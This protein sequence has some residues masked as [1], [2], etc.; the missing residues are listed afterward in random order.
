M[1]L[2]L[3]GL[4]LSLVLLAPSIAH[5]EN[6]SAPA[7]A[8]AV[9]EARRHFVRGVDLFKE[10]DHRGALIEFRRAQSLAPNFRV[11]FNIG[12]TLMMLQEY[13]GARDAFRG[14]LDKGSVSIPAPRRAAVEEE[15]KRLEAR[16][17]QVEI[18]VNV[19]GAEITIDDEVVG[20][21][22]LGGP[23]QVSA[24]RR[25]VTVSSAGTQSVT[26]YVDV[27]GADQ[28]VVEVTLIEAIHAPA[29]APAPIPLVIGDE[30]SVPSRARERN[31]GRPS[32]A[33]WIAAGATGILTAGAV[34]SGILALRAKSDLDKHV[35]S[36]GAEIADIDSA[37]NRAR[38]FSI[39]TDV[40]GACA[41]VA[42]GV[43]GYLFFTT[44]R[45]SGVAVA[46]SPGRVG[47]SGSF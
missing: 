28:T 44:R 34:V 4:V 36:P 29:V 15:V 21:A 47:L 9:D 16:I 19:P 13:A 27:V 33:P 20:V 8:A 43:T 38:T 42:A 5:A 2:Y 22:P 12:Q 3:P 35:A 17:G 18:R 32:S 41:V 14:Y 7:T 1:R 30:P 31:E 45:S 25:K 40:L 26:R 11:L 37:R 46:V 6:P 10:G 39:G 23:L 24:G